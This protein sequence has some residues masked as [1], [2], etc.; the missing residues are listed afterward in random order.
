MKLSARY[1][2]LIGVVAAGLFIPFLWS[3]HLFDWDEINFAECAREMIKTHD[4]SRVYV[5]F[6]PFWEKPPMFFWMQAICMQLFGVNEFAARLPN[7]ICGIAT[8][9]TVFLC[10]SKI[11]DRRFGLLWAIAF[12]GSIF[13]NMYFKSGIIDPWYN[14]FT[15]LALYFFILYHWKTNGFD[16]EGL[17][18]SPMTYT[19]YAGIFM[20]LAVLTKGQVALMVFLLV[21]GVYL[22]Y[23]HFRLFFKWPNA[24]LFLVVA[25]LVTVTWYGWETMKHGPWFITQ[26]LKYQYRLFSTH[27]AGQKG[28]FG[29]HYVMLLIGC[30]PASIFAIPSFFRIT[31]ET[32][33]GKD[34]RKWMIFLFWTV[35]ILFTIVQSRIIHYSSLAWF[36][37]TFL[38]A[39]T[40][41]QWTQNKMTFKKYVSVGVGI[42]GGVVALAV[43][44]VPFFALNIKKFI[45]YVNDKFAQANMQADVYWSGWES[46][47]GL[48]LLII[49]IIGINRLKRN[50]FQQVAWTFFGG[51][52]IFIFLLSAIIIPKIERYS[53]GAAI[54]FLKQRR[55]EDCYVATLGYKSYAELFYTQKEKPE[56]PNY[57][58]LDWLLN[59]AIDKPVYFV[60]R[61]NRVDNY[62][63]SPGIRELYRKNGFVFLRRDPPVR[64]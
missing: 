35:T 4:Y 64:N 58:N 36:P 17:T 21:L 53:Q 48:W 13:P 3:T 1:G 41:Y 60:S 19:I 8:L 25:T 55:G 12:G 43:I 9:V 59:G 49:I 22:V 54:D 7:A 42:I 24:I 15:F 51:V 6:K 46:L 44:A 14:L 57:Y 30:F 38:A 10:G 40:F 56:N 32:R 31:E 11:F 27:D 37:L 50:E 61:V 52:A 34:F 23:N 16:K 5:D 39:H 2:I 47:I 33:F 63:N 29:Y 18:R 45:P 20:G 28:F 62:M 26:F